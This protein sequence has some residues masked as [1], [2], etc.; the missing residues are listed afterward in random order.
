MKRRKFRFI[1]LNTC[2]IRTVYKFAPSSPPRGDLESNRIGSYSSLQ[3]TNINHNFHSSFVLSALAILL[4]K[5][6]SM[7]FELLR[8]RAMTDGERERKSPECLQTLLQLTPRKAPVTLTDR[9]SV[10]FIS[11]DFEYSCD[12][13]LSRKVEEIGISTLDTRDLC[14]PLSEAPRSLHSINRSWR[15]MNPDFRK[16]LFGESKT[17]WPK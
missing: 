10:L 17:V 11:I 1:S 12:K 6:E 4:H 14:R 5:S 7:D 13:H 3:F 16:F 9:D 15:H 8:R 2:C